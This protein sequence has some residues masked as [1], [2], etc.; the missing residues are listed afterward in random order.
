M[1]E[2]QKVVQH[3]LG[4]VIATDQEVITTDATETELLRFSGVGYTQGNGM[5]TASVRVVAR[6]PLTNDSASW[7]QQVAVKNTTD[8][9]EFIGSLPPAL[10]FKDAAIDDIDIALTFD[11]SSLV[12]S[13][14]GL[15]NAVVF[16]GAAIT[17]DMMQY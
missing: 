7:S 10:V 6:N 4:A 14:T 2:K 1:G 16:W 13:V 9:A 12:V 17:V 3:D 15:A 11:G 8:A 5:W